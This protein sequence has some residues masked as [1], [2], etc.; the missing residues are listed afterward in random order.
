MG[1]A[2]SPDTLRV[3]VAGA[4]LGCVRWRGRPGSPFVVA[5]HGITANAWSWGNVAHHLNGEVGLV[6]IDLRGRGA[7]HEALPPFGMRGHADDIAAVIARLGTAPAVITGHSMGAHVAM[8]C[9]ERHPA[10][11]ASL[12]LVDG[13]PPIDR[14][15]ELSSDAM[16]EQMLGPAIERLRKVWPDRVTYHAMWSAHPAFAGGLTLEMERYLLSDLVDCEGGFRSNVSEDAVRF[17]G[18]ELLSDDE[19]RGLFARHTG[20]L[21]VVRA[22]T[23]LLATPPP[24]VPERFVDEYPGH[25]WRFVEGSNHYSIMFG[26]SGAAEIADALRQAVAANA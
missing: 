24:F 2:N 3:T 25:D 1:P 19:V 7:S 17:D 10:A 11:V 21:T 22:E 8:M 23:G 26:E 16:L 20:R 5:V 4:E 13:G 15:D 12:V 6:A 14:D 9:A 18:V